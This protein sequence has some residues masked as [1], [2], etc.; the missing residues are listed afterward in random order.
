MDIF[1]H[2]G[3]LFTLICALIIGFYLFFN[4]EPEPDVPYESGILSAACG[5]V[6][7]VFY[8]ESRKQPV[9]LSKGAWSKVRPLLTDVT[10]KGWIIVVV[11]NIHDIHVQRCPVGGT[12]KSVRHFPGKFKPAILGTAELSALENERL[13]VSIES[14][15]IG[16][17]KVVQIAG[18]LA[19]R[20]RCYL[21]PGQ[22]VKRGEKLGKILLGSMVLLFIPDIDGKGRK[23]SPVVKPG[24]KVIAAETFITRE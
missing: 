5:K 15:G 3:L 18:V 4:R 8:Y 23:I 2:F 9:L 13:E 1:L 22:V 11:M 20:T 12:V 19:R 14:P 7:S 24:D 21:K 10:E 6:S 16:R 17:I